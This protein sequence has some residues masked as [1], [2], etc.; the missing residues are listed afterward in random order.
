M[1]LLHNDINILTL[2]FNIRLWQA[3]DIHLERLNSKILIN[4]LT[5]TL[6]KQIHL[7]ELYIQTEITIR[8]KKRIINLSGLPTK[9]RLF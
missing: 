3:S 1:F 9:T 8:A 5:T 2:T 6:A 4:I 7:N